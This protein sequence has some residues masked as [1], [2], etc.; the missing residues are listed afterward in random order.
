VWRESPAR[1][2]GLGVKV[3]A[4]PSLTP[5]VGEILLGGG[6]AGFRV[7]WAERC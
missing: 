2:D 6:E 3:V 5:L 4:W 7:G 1:G